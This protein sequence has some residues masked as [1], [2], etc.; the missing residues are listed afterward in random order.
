MLNR[1]INTQLI[2]RDTSINSS[3]L[4]IIPQN[5]G[6][7]VRPNSREE[8]VHNFST[9]EIAILTRFRD[10]THLVKNQEP[11][12]KIPAF[13]FRSTATEFKDAFI[14]KSYNST[15][16]S[17]FRDVRK[18]YVSYIKDFHWQGD[19]THLMVGQTKRLVTN[20]LLY[21]KCCEED[22]WV[23]LLS[24]LNSVINGSELH[25][26]ALSSVLLYSIPFA[27]TPI[28]VDPDLLLSYQLIAREVLV[29]TCDVP[30]VYGM[31]IQHYLEHSLPGVQNLM[32]L[33]QD[34]G[35]TMDALLNY[36][37]QDQLSA[38]AKRM[39]IRSV[40]YIGPRLLP[41]LMDSALNSVLRVAE[42]TRHAGRLLP[43]P[44][45]VVSNPPLQE[46]LVVGCPTD[47]VINYL[48]GSYGLPYFS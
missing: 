15:T 23:P 27:M 39:V 34:V 9:N 37:D 11:L 26:R 36:F 5:I 7:N 35:E 44:I 46:A 12:D 2:A 28:L 19:L 20:I 40:C 24:H 47:A 14:I 13:S 32:A 21:T 1:S 6:D 16:N 18:E 17:T 41:V 45:D 3:A 38:A 4:T 33:S 29:L 42:N 8:M 48:A 31:K 30:L 25:L 10:M 22:Q 43:M